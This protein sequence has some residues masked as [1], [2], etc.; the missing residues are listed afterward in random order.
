MDVKS[1]QKPLPNISCHFLLKIS[2]LV[3][4]YFL[5]VNAFVRLFVFVFVFFISFSCLSSRQN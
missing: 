5:N 1:R 3:N 2:F 4:F